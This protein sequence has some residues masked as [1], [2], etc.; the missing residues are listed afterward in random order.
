MEARAVVEEAF[1]AVAAADIDRLLER[2]APDCVFEDVP[3]GDVATGR[4]G[5]RAVMDDYYAGL[6][7]YHVAE[8]RF[9]VDGSDVAVELVLAGTH[10]GSFL[11]HSATRGMISWKACAT[12]TVDQARGV[13]THERYYYDSA[14]L[15]SQLSG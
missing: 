10:Q 9:I 13:I 2:F 11:G 4:D 8:A 12:Y 6:P 3:S 1:A 5:L 15:I 14:S 7:D